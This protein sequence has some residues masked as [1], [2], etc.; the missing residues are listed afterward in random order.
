MGLTIN[1]AAKIIE[2]SKSLKNKRKVVCLGEPLLPFNFKQLLNCCEKLNIDTSQLIEPSN[3]LNNLSAKDFFFWLGF[4]EYASMDVSPY[5]GSEIIHDLN[6]KDLNKEYFDIADLVFDGGTLEHIFNLPNALK[7]IFNLLKNDGIAVHH[8]PTNG[9]LDHG[10]FQICPTFYYDYYKANQFSNISGNIIKRYNGELSS[11]PYLTDIYRN[12][13]MFYGIKN[14]PRATLFFCAMKTKN[15]TCHK[16]PTQTY[17]NQMHS[18][19]V[20]QI[21][22]EVE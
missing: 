17:Y 1:D 6:N 11:E 9:Y 2:I 8:N 3:M 18:K 21:F 5:E 7:C 12:K 22:H 19:F 4:E 13:G 14:F 20:Q 10:F 15:S 16:V